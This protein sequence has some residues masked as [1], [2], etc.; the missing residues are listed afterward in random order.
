MNKKFQLKDLFSSYAQ[1]CN[2]APGADTSADF[3]SLRGSAVA[4]RKRIVAIIG[5]NTF[6]DIVAIGDED[7]C[8]KDF[9][10]AAMANLTLATQ[11]IFDAVNRRKN[12]VNLYKYELEGMKRSYM[13]N[14][15]NAMDSL[16]SELTGDISDDETAEIRLAMEDWRKTNYYRMLS[17]LKV[18]TADEFDEIYPIDLSYLF[19]FRCVPLQ[20]EVLDESIGAYF[21]RLEKGGEDQTFAEF[22]QKALPMLKRALV[23]K[24]VAKSLR[25][26]DILEFP[27]TIR[28]LFV[29]CIHLFRCKWRLRRI[30]YHIHPIRIW[31]YQCFSCKGIGTL[32]LDLKAFRI[33][34][35]SC[36]HLIIGWQHDSII[37]AFQIFCFINRPLNKRNI[38]HSNTTCQRIRKLHNGFFTHAIGNYICLAVQQNGSLKTV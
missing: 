24:T 22:G 25:R 20:K 11:I 3:D 21:E 23:K 6:F 31:L 15:F 12:D 9:L 29:D 10:R 14:Y 8:L 19:F 27:A 37:D 7:S 16:I 30:L 36:L 4:A 34:L 5:S 35:R 28:N 32:I 18:D 26:F 1:F 13:E 17:Q 33:L 38:F 2:S